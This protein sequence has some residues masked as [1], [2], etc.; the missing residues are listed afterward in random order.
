MVAVAFSTGVEEQVEAFTRLARVAEQF[1]L[2]ATGGGKSLSL[3][4]REPSFCREHHR[5]ER[6][7]FRTAF[8]TVDSRPAPAEVSQHPAVV[9]A[10][11]VANGA[12]QSVIVELP[13]G[14]LASTFDE[15]LSLKPDVIAVTTTPA[16]HLLKKA[17]SMGL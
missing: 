7:W 8:Q 5:K 1:D 6:C 11:R 12:D 13:L 2:S 3:L 4:R 16:A 15:C 10:E 17:T 9:K 14:V